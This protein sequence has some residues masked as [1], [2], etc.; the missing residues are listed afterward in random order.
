[1]TAE[2][3]LAEISLKLSEALDKLDGLQL[4]LQRGMTWIVTPIGEFGF[5]ARVTYGEFWL[6]TLVCGWAAVWLVR[7]VSSLLSPGGWW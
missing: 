2:D 3:L 7:K 1:M 5:L 6:A 4:L